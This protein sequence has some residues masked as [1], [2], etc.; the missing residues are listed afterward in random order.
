[1]IKGYPIFENAFS[2]I[3]RAT[4]CNIKNRYNLRKKLERLN[5]KVMEI[6]KGKYLID[7]ATLHQAVIRSGEY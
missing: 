4:I 5:V 6:Q 1:V 7:L 3:E 2:K